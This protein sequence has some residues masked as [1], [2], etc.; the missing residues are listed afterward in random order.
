MVSKTT[1]ISSHGS[2]RELWRSRLLRDVAD[3]A[4]YAIEPTGSDAGNENG[5][6]ERTNGTFGAMARCLLYSTG[7]S[8]KFWSAALVHAVYLKNR[9]FHKALQKTPY[10]EWTGVKPP[11]GH[12]RTFGALLIATEAWQETGQR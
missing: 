4:G 1:A 2:K 3:K 12:L 7:L 10:E 9:L 11:L 8:T 6:V 5:K